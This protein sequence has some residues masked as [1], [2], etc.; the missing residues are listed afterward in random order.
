MLTLKSLFIRYFL[1][2]HQIKKE[3]AN[4][5][6]KKKKLKKRE[7]LINF[8]NPLKTINIRR[9][10]I[11]NINTIKMDY[12]IKVEISTRVILIR[13]IIIIIK[14]ILRNPQK[15]NFNININLAMK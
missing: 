8:K 14:I 11:R 1:K 9:S 3:N 7:N 6:L 12:R 4:S 5:K 15:K 10:H 13:Q 2:N